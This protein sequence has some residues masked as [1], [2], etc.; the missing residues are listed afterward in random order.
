MRYDLLL[1]TFAAFALACS[2]S[3]ADEGQSAASEP[4]ATRA[5]RSNTPKAAD[6]APFPQILPTMDPPPLN[7]DA[8][9]IYA[10]ADDCGLKIMA[11]GDPGL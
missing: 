5:G 7:E 3:P 9:E 4:L 11:S 1:A 10:P 6:A 2:D 8:C